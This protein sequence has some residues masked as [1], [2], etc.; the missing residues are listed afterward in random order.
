MHARRIIRRATVSR[1]DLGRFHPVDQGA[2]GLSRIEKRLGKEDAL[3][4]LSRLN[5]LAGVCAWA[6]E[7]PEVAI[8]ECFNVDKI[9][10]M[11]QPRRRWV[12]SPSPGPSLPDFRSVRRPAGSTGW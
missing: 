8:F 5:F 7:V 12:S 2:G 4:V 9:A 6:T 11:E 10:C 3:G 1:E